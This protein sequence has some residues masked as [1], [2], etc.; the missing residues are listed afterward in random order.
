MEKKYFHLIAYNYLVVYEDFKKERITDSFVASTDNSF[1]TKSDLVKMAKVAESNCK[2]KGIFDCIVS[3][4]SL[5][6]MTDNQF[7]YA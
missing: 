5:G 1:L 2:D 3:I 7:N 4:S 6:Q